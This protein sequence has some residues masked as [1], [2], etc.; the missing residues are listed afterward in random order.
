MSCGLTFNL[1]VRTEKSSIIKN[2]LLDRRSNVVICTYFYCIIIIS[3]KANT[4]R[5]EG[6]DGIWHLTTIVCVKTCKCASRYSST[7][8][9]KRTWL[10]NC[11]KF[12]LCHLSSMHVIKIFSH[13]SYLKLT[14]MESEKLLTEMEWPKIFLIIWRSMS[15]WF[16]IGIYYFARRKSGT[17]IK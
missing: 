1:K 7:F 12:T 6:G 14:I 11:P 16:K 17:K 9:H 5:L 13:A 10:R 3:H 15:E 4:V 8:H 2:Y